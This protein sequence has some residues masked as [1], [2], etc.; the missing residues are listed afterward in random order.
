[1]SANV[2]P[3]YSRTPDIQWSTVAT[4]NTAKDGTGTVATAFAADATE[5]GRVE[6]IKVR[7]LGTNTETV[8]R[9]FINNGSTNATA[10][11]NSLFMEV[12]MPGTTV[13]EVAAQAD[14][15]VPMNLALPPGYKLNVTVGTTVAAGFAVTAVGGKY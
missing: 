8:L 5:G 15:E 11:N 4:A 12:T 14:T 10:A 1:M 6:K 9:I 7:P 3:I 2:N 13:S